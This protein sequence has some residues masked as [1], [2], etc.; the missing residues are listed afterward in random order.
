MLL[1]RLET[2]L[3]GE[4][5]WLLAAARGGPGLV[6]DPG[7]GAAADIEGIC[8][9]NDLNV[10]AVLASHGHID[11]VA[12]AAAVSERWRVP[13]W[14][15]PAE[16]ELLA[17]PAAGLNPGVQPVIGDL[18]ASRAPAQPHEVRDLADRQVLDLA[19]F[20]VTVLHTPGHRPGCVLFR[21]PLGDQTVVLTG[22][23]L[24]AGS[25]GRTDLPGSSPKAM[26]ASL[27]DVV[28]GTGDDGQPHLPGDVI[29]LPGHGRRTTMA[30]ERVTNPYLQADFLETLV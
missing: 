13:V 15:H 26:G 14:I 16:R 2:A 3:W 28:L 11:H 24:F 18:F 25:I 17:D 23:V 22:D 27:R 30:V 21:I 12:D 10:A 8:A 1:K 29:V 20:A 19:G 9:D 6:I 4:N 5:C 7:L